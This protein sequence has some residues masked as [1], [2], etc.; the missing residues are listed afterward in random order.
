MSAAVQVLAME[1][2]LAGLAEL[3]FS[4]ALLETVASTFLVE[5][6]RHAFFLELQGTLSV[7]V[8]L[9]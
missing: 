4:L 7:S 5:L 3:A 1:E 2:S 6:V 8:Q 9:A